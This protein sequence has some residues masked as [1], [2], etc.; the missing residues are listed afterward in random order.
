M[1][2]LI[3]GIFNWY[4]EYSGSGIL[5]VLFFVVLIYIALE[6]ENRSNRTVLLYGTVILMLIIFFPGTYYIYTKY[7]DAGT[8]WRFFWLIPMGIGLAY[9]GAK[10]TEKHALAGGL[11][12]MVV[13]MLGG[14]F[15]YNSRVSFRIAE[16]LYQLP[17]EV[18]DI[19]DYLESRELEEIRCAVSPELLTYIR[20]Y[21]VNI[22]MPYGREQ[23]DS[24]WSEKSGFFMLMAD[25][26]INPAKLAEK[27]LYNHTQFIVVNNEKALL[28]R[29]E[30]CGFKK[31]YTSGSFDVY[32]YME[33]GE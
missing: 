14:S 8:Y 30:N 32:E 7:V 21:D 20:Q 5:T 33:L 9:A 10:L 27:C 29:P 3:S 19:A 28:N 25:A 2:D 16:N 26:N 31:V 18:I 1:M 4:S 12:V 17:G 23:L 13:L 6:D 22:I 11:M 15:I 24:R